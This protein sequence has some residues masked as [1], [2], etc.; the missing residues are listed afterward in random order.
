LGPGGT[1]WIVANR[2]LAYEAVIKKLFKDTQLLVE[3]GGF[4]VYKAER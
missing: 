2:H 4:K 3:T 1:A